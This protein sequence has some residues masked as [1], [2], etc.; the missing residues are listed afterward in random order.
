MIDGCTRIQAIIRVILPLMKNQILA[1]TIF[2]FLFMWNDFLLALILTTSSEIRPV[3]V[4]LT[5][6]FE[7]T[8]VDWGALMSASLLMTFPATVLFLLYQRHLVRGLS[9]GAVKN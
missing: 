5:F 3:S 2:I 1:V 6:Y 9:E 7:E 8:Y 4:G